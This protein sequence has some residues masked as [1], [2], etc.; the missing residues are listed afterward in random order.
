MNKGA[1]MK[2]RRLVR[3]ILVLSIVVA[4]LLYVLSAIWKINAINLFRQYVYYPIPESVS[5]IKVDKPMSRG[6]YGYV[7]RFNIKREDFETI[8]KSRSFRKIVNID[9]LKGEGLYWYWEDWDI[10]KPG[11]EQGISFSMYALVRKP[12]WY[13]LPTWVNPEA[14]ALWNVDTN[15]NVDIQVLLYNSNLRQAYFVTFHYDGRGL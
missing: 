11:G 3:Y 4:V 15:K 5:Q 10:T 12:S 7:F 13:D 6:G 2:P 9:Y 14:Y 1:T 8:R